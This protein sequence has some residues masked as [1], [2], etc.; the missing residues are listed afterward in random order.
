MRAP[1]EHPAN[2][3]QEQPA[4]KKLGCARLSP[5]EHPSD[6]QQILAF[7]AAQR[8]RARC[9]DPRASLIHEAACERVN[10]AQVAVDNELVAEVENEAAVVKPCAAPRMRSTS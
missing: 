7:V 3:S 4:R 5:T 2:R 10:L 8:R 6:P 1:A 9:I